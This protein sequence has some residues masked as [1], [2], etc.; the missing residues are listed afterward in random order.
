MEDTKQVQ[1]LKI[2]EMAK[3]RRH[4]HLLEKMQRGKSDTPSLSKSEI[5]ELERLAA[6]PSSPG[7]VDSQE[8]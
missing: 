7:I 3:K 8:K 2:V 4:I 6:D 1:N 5:K